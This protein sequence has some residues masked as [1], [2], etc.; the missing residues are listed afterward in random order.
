LTL[1]SFRFA[2]VDPDEGVDIPVPSGTT[3][4]ASAASASASKFLVGAAIVLGTC[5]IGTTGVVSAAE[6]RDLQLLAQTQSV[7]T[8]PSG[9][10]AIPG[11][12]GRVQAILRRIRSRGGLTWGEVAYAVGVSRRAVHNWLRG[13]RIAPSHD[14]LLTRLDRLVDEVPG[15]TVEERRV[16][17]TVAGLNG[18][19]LLDDLALTTRKGRRV[20]LSSVSVADQLGPVRDLQPGDLQTPNRPSRLKGGPLPKRKLPDE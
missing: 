16:A 2:H 6:A 17:L 20:P 18:R 3:S 12:S 8:V 5:V 9:T 1:P 14:A 15:T 7:G 10:G 11:E 4:T 19:S 13:D